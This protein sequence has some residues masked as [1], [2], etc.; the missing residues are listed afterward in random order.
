[1][2]GFFNISNHATSASLAS[3]DSAG[4]PPNCYFFWPI[5]H[6]ALENIA[7]FTAEYLLRKTIFTVQP[8]MFAIRRSNSVPSFLNNLLHLHE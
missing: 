4:T 2:Q 7:A 6:I 5:P 3:F 8:P 1:E